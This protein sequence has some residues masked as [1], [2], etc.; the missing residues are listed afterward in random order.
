VETFE[1]L[2]E[3]LAATPFYAWAGITLLSS[4]DGTVELALDVVPHHLNV[5]G[6]AH[7]GMLATLADTAAGLAVRTK[8]EP[9]RRHVTVQLS[10]QYLS[11][12]PTGRVVARGR[13]VRVGSQIA[14]AEADIVDENGREL[15]RATS[16]LSVTQER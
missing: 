12:A 6:L 2:A 16:T 8:L 13:A 10:V 9:G 11:P 3:R 7:G 14:Y 1:E 5:Q 4:G 15:V